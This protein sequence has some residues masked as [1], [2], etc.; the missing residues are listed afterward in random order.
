[1]EANLAIAGFIC[2]VMLI[3]I[4]WFVLIGTGSY[5][6]T[7][8]VALCLFAA[9][10]A[11]QWLSFQWWSANFALLGGIDTLAIP[12]FAL[13]MLLTGTSMANH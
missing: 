8:V 7:Q 5:K 2:A 13:V 6:V 4:P 1:M 10:L 11:F 9:T 12:S 3:F